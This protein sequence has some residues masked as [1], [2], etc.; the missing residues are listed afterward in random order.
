MKA[1]ATSN[2]LKVTENTLKI[3]QEYVFSIPFDGTADKRLKPHFYKS[4][5]YFLEHLI[6]S[7]TVSRGTK[8]R[9]KFKGDD[10]WTHSV[11]FPYALGREIAPAVFKRNSELQHKRGLELLEE[12]KI[13]KIITHSNIKHKCRE[14]CLSIKFLNNL[15]TCDRKQYL[16]RKD[17]YYRLADIYEK[18]TSWW[19]EDL[20]TSG[21]KDTGAIK[22]KTSR[23]DVP[24]KSYRDLV[25]QVYNSLDSLRINIDA[26]MDYC[27]KN[28]SVKNMSYFY[29]FIS[30]M[31]NL[32]T[33][34]ISNN[35]LVIAYKQF[36]KTASKGGR[37]FELGTGFQYLPKGMK[38]SSL[39][40][41]YN[42]DIKSCQLKILK[43]E[44]KRHGISR[45]NL[46]LLST[47]QI[48]K[49]LE[50]EEK[51]A[52]TF[53]FAVI[54]NLGAVSTSPRSNVMRSLTKIHGSRRADKL[55]SKWKDTLFPLRKDL[56]K[57]VDIYSKQGRNTK[58]G[59]FVENAV[60]QK[61]NCGVLNERFGMTSAKKRK[62]MA[63]MIQGI[64]SRAVYDFVLTNKNVCALEHDGFVSL[65]ELQ[66]DAWQHPYLKLVMK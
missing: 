51:H 20:L 46:K 39:A 27:N 19:I 24:D 25:S 55:L 23:R 43:M 65:E 6:C 5:A 4:I 10:I 17:R 29:N 35:P 36:Y 18:G 45:A 8:K 62:L 58:H 49:A 59:Y 50:V 32:E 44:F 37:S 28:P 30:H 47:E 21:L 11:P 3:F 26:M 33:D 61:F 12:Y 2:N 22:N 63:H 1:Y 56:L 34:I 7:A 42:Y 66:D 13:I 41:G 64:E 53:R 15:I 38:W 31:G 52:K 9:A 54:F 48:C 57:L 40:E 16:S 14:F 60:G